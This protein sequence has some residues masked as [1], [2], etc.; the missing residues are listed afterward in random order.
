M[1]NLIALLLGLT[2]IGAVATFSILAARSQAKLQ[3]EC[4]K[5]D[6]CRS[7]EFEIAMNKVRGR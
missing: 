5:L 6:G 1:T 7:R 2:A 3:R 4:V